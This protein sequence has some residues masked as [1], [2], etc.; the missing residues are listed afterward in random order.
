MVSFNDVP[1][2]LR[3]PFVA[4]E[5]DASRA[6][7]GPALLAYR[8]LLLGQKMNSGSAAANSLHRVTSADDVVKICG[9]GSML[10]R[11]ALA[12]FSGNKS[13]ETWIGVLGDNSSGVRATG[14]VTVSGTATADGTISLYLGGDLVQIAVASGDSASTIASAIATEIGKHAS[15]TIT[16]SSADAADNVTIGATTFVGTAGAVVAGAA[17]YSIDTGDNAAATSLAA[18]INA[19]AVASTVVFATASSNVVTVRAVEGGTA[20]NSIVLTSTDG[21]DLAVSGTGTL[22]GGTAAEDHAVHASVS[23]AV[24]TL[25]AKNVGAVANEYDVRVNYQPDSEE[26]PAGVS[27][28]IVDMASGATN[29]TLTSMISAMGDQWFNIIAHPYTDATSLTALETELSS[30]FGSMR[31]IDGIM[32]TAKDASYATVSALGDSRNSQHSS[33]LRVN[34]SPTPPAEYAAHVAAV[35]AYHLQKDP[36]RPLQTLALPYIKA[37]ADSDLDTLEERNL[38]LYDGISTTRVG[39]GGVVQIERLVTTYQTNAANSPDTAYLDVTTMATLMYLR[40]SFRSLI[41]SKFP[42]HKL[43]S[44]GTRF[45]AGQAVVTPKIM[46]SE[47]YAWFRQMEELGLVEGFDQFKTD[48]VVVRNESDPNRLDILLPPNIIN[49]LIVTAAKI[50]FLV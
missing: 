14:T 39:S 16:L 32:I 26:T 7:Q 1:S 43:A 3:V 44:D 23:G 31:M 41:A 42:H 13:T 29:P 15:G 27:L 25:H 4:A 2:N 48:L 50:Q 20:G 5:F 34:D 24:V 10:H 21:V 18:Q 8:A 45:G 47:C 17:T 40:Y 12:W 33:I 49:A 6:S 36:A 38:L 9:R 37:P 35:A 28:A 30:R 46:K 11:M 19:H 22:S